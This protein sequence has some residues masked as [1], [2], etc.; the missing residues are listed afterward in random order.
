M[1]TNN[2]S[3][4]VAYGLA[5]SQLG[6]Y[7]P[8][9][10]VLDADLAKAT[11]TIKFAEKYPD[12][13][14]DFGIAEQNM[15]SA[16]AGLATMEFIT[17]VSTFAIFASMRAVEQFRNMVAYPELNVKLV[18]THGGTENSGD[19]ATHQ[20]IED[21]AIM[22]TIPNVK[23][24]VPSDYFS[25]YKAVLAIAD[26]QGPVYLRL[27]RSE[28]QTIYNENFNFKVGK[29]VELFSGEDVTIIAIGSMV[30]KAVFAREILESQ[31]IHARIIDLLT[32]K[33]LDEEAILR[34]AIETRGIVT[35]EDHNVYG[36]MGSVI[37]EFLAEKYPTRVLRVGINDHFGCSGDLEELRE[38][39]GL[40]VS[41]IVGKVKELL[42]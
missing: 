29:S 21:I 8:K 37:A 5:L 36:G 39:F 38:N 14:F 41:N 24:I 6:E 23:V 13:F 1:V 15:V 25:T 22:R 2:M 32:I 34:A 18:V 12:R 9:V 27:G 28:S 42:K 31:G 3:N 10:I 4:R 19:G 40:S 7:N 16:A 35:V 17:F 20:S 11:Y 30:E 33:P 26:I